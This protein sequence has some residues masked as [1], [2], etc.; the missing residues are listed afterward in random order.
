MKM[1]KK[2][3]KYIVVAL[4][5][6]VLLCLITP[7]NNTLRHRSIKHQINYLSN[8]LDKGYDDKL[9]TKFPE[10]KLF[11]NCLLALATIEFCD[12]YDQS[13]TRYAT[14]VD[15]CIR[16]IQSEKALGVF[17]SSLQPKYG[18][19]YQGWSNLVYSKYKNSELLNFSKSPK[20]VRQKSEEIE[21]S[22]NQIQ[23]DSLRIID[24]Y[25]GSNWPADNLIGIASIEND[26][27]R[28]RWIELILKTTEHAS[29]LIHH[30][31]SLK[32]RIRGSSSAMITYCLNLSGYPEINTYK[33]KF[34]ETFIDNYLGVQLVKE[35][36]DGSN[37]MDVDSGPILFGYGASA[38]MMNI[39]TQASLGK[40][41]AKITWATMNL[42][43]L[44]INIFG[45][46]YLI[47]KK[48]PML[49]LFM[50]WASTEL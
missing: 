50:L 31:G 2:I 35:N 14:I 26:S 46:K 15:N 38:T 27:L 45:K 44:P 28:L 30:S 48:E 25:M 49:D 1:I 40:S 47:F 4:L 10:G 12:K 37:R 23:S 3:L 42:I 41:N 16:R 29:G 20:L 18:M 43:S 7:F 39:K 19:F 34:E 9:Q 24:T 6:Y 32:N 13:N 22:I 8:I 5:A 11:S 36:E 17:D 21:S 33:L